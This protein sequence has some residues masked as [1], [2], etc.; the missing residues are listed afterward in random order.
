MYDYYKFTEVFV[1][2]DEAECDLTGTRKKLAD[3]TTELELDVIDGGNN[4]VSNNI[5]AISNVSNLNTYK[6]RYMNNGGNVQDFNL[7][8]P[9]EISYSWGTV[10]AWAHC[11]VDGTMAN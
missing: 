8:I 5:V 2:L 11:T 9:I 7:W 10:K 1:N 3:V 4:T 6:V